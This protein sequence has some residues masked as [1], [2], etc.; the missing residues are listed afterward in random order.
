[1]DNRE[2]QNLRRKWRKLGIPF[3]V[4]DKHI[5]ASL[6]AIELRANTPTR[7]RPSPEPWSPG[8]RCERLSMWR[9]DKHRRACRQCG[10]PI[11]DGR[12]LGTCS[13]KCR[14]LLQAYEKSKG[15]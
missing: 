12:T 15:A 3:A 11:P 5:A 4:I 2:I 10:A 9:P 8:P 14:K 1:M 6:A 7:H 13:T